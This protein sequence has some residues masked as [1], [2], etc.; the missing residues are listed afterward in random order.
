[1]THN[2][3]PHPN[4]DSH[5]SVAWVGQSFGASMPDILYRSA[6]AGDTLFEVMS[7]GSFAV[8]IRSAARASS[9]KLSKF[10]VPVSQRRGAVH[11]SR[12]VNPCKWG[13]GGA[14]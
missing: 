12:P 6:S 11:P 7:S 1:M 5:Y 3:T 4:P 13:R 9:S 10:L 8:G 14:G 2:W